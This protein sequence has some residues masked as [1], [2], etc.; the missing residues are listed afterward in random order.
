MSGVTN[1]ESTIVKSEV[2]AA[3]LPIR[4][5]T[6][7]PI[8]STTNESKVAAIEILRDNTNAASGWLYIGTHNGYGWTNQTIELGRDSTD[9]IKGSSRRV[10]NDV[11]L[12]TGKPIRVGGFYSLAGVD[13]VRVL[14]NDE[15]VRIEEVENMGSNRFWAHVSVTSTNDDSSGK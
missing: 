1:L 4:N 13:A 11:Y 2:K 5:D 12:R 14:V 7:T 3:N 10:V 9:K 15:I 6:E 8:L